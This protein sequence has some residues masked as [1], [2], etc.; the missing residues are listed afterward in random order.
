MTHSK[1]L[2]TKSHMLCK[3]EKTNHWPRITNWSIRIHRV[4]MKEYS[5]LLNSCHHAIMVQWRVQWTRPLSLGPPFSL[6]THSMCRLTT[7]WALGNSLSP[8]NS[9]INRRQR[10][11]HTVATATKALFSVSFIWPC[12]IYDLANK[13]LSGAF[14]SPRTRAPAYTYLARSTP[15]NL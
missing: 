3:N 8:N 7:T 2:C 10:R 6:C 14:T 9:W 15:I 11:T 12:S 5:E 4:R 13:R 1:V